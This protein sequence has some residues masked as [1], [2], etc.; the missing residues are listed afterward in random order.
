MP[1]EAT[2]DFIMHP[3][4]EAAR[5]VNKYHLCMILPCLQNQTPITLISVLHTY[6]LQDLA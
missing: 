3:I 5:E 2:T 6:G 1:Q 4:Y